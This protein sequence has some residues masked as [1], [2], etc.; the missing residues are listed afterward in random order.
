MGILSIVW[1]I[2]ALIGCIVAATP[3]LGSLNW[4]NIPFAVIGVIFGAV[5]M[6]KAE[7]HNQGLAGLIMG[8]LAVVWGSIR[9]VLG[10]GVL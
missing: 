8:I 1:G 2:F 7:T 4:I 9:L 3:C 6:S 5:A 10:G